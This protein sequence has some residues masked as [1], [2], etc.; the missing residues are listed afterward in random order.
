MRGGAE[1][2]DMHDVADSPSDNDHFPPVSLAHTYNASQTPVCVIGIAYSKG[3]S[4]LFDP[5]Y[6]TDHHVMKVFEAKSTTFKYGEPKRVGDLSDTVQRN[7]V[8]SVKVA[9]FNFVKE[10]IHPI[11]AH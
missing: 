1:R 10:G 4:Q 2:L 3:K 7:S 11:Q 9:V 5:Q 6:A 8:L